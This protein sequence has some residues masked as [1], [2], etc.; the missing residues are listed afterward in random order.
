MSTQAS[1]RPALNLGR[2]LVLLV[3]FMALL[4][5]PSAKADTLLG[6]NT[7]A[8]NSPG[9]FPDQYLA[10]SF[11]LTT[12]IDLTQLNV[13]IGGFG[14]G[15]VLIQLTDSLSS[16]ATVYMSETFGFPS[17]NSIF[18]NGQLLG[19]AGPI[20]L[21]PG[22]YYIVVSSTDGGGWWPTVSGVLSSTVGSV[23]GNFFTPS[24]GVDSAFPPGS[25]WSSCSCGPLGFQL[26]GSVS[27]VPEPGTLMLLGTGLVGLILR[28]RLAP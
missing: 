23:G 18:P 19:L 14:S 1:S 20:T 27:S 26:E 6:T 5:V 12:G 22:T 8:T 7:T 17:T 2:S 13:L 21:G 3:M 11:S 28:R 9:I 25:T 15:N 24:G 16:G 4:V 10:Q